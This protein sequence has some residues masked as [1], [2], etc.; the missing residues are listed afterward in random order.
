MT[1]EFVAVGSDSWGN[2]YEISAANDHGIIVSMGSP[3]QA[4]MQIVIATTGS[5]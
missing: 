4:A 3:H 5:H 2:F 1:N